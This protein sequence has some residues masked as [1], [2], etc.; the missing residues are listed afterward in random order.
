M[1]GHLLLDFDFG[2]DQELFSLVKVKAEGPSSYWQLKKHASF[3]ESAHLFEGLHTLRS[4]IIET[5]LRECQSIKTK[6]LF[7]V[8]AEHL[9]YPWVSKLD[10]ADI[11]FG[12]GNR[13][14]DEGGKTHPKYNI[15]VND[16]FLF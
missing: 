6:R 7:M 12:K 1:I 13:V 10:L 2:F 4:E 3:S 14:I 9:N 11:D 15:T 5:L 8:V 16:P